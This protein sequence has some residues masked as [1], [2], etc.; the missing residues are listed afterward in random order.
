MKSFVLFFVFFSIFGFCKTQDECPQPGVRKRTIIRSAESIENGA[1]LLEKYAVDSARQCYKKCCD[2]KN[3]NVAVMHYK[4]KIQENGEELMQKFC[5]LFDCKSPS[6]CTYD[7]HTRYA[8]IEVPKK[9]NL[10]TKE[11]IP[12]ATRSTHGLQPNKNEEKE[13]KIILILI[14]YVF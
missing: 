14:L 3:C 12:T 1:K 8:I 10:V 5:F 6:V 11:L 13:S 7:E 9:A 2:M 4:Q